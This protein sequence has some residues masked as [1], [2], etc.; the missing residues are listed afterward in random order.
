[1]YIL[2]YTKYIKLGNLTAKKKCFGVKSRYLLTWTSGFPTTLV[3][4]VLPITTNNKVCIVS[5]GGN[6]VP[7]FPFIESTLTK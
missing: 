2:C 4:C 1:M 3:G 5:G 7:S 6:A